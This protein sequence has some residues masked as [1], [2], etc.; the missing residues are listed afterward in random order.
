MKKILS[1]ITA[2]S[3]TAACGVSVFAADKENGEPDVIVNGSKIIFA[4]QNAKIVDDVTL[5]PARGV[6][7]AMG[8]KVDWNDAS[9]AVTVT[10]ETGVKEVI[11]TIDSDVMKISRFKSLF[12]KEENDYTLEVPAQIIN[13]RTMIPLRAVSEAFDC[14]VEW[15]GGA[16]AVNITTGDP[17]LLE[18]Y[19]YTAPDADSLVQMSLSTDKTGALEAGEEFTIYVDAKNIPE[20]SFIS[21]VTATFVYDK[22]KFEYVVDSGSLIN[23][24]DEEFEGLSVE[25]LDYNNGAKVVFVTIDET[26]GRKTGGHA[27]KATFKSINGESGTIALGNSFHSVIGYESSIMCTTGTSDKTYKGKNLSLDTTPL[28]IG[29]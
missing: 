29:E 23:D 18:G 19:T 1:L 12:E 2:L 22:D 13:D 5:V 10:S 26:N 20:D 7:E 14:T 21:G 3:M 9:R 11:I 17:I 6:F 4:D 27:Y 25:N 15:D 16:Y 8:C 24:N 28:T